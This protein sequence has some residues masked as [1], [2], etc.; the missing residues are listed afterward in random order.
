MTTHVEP[1]TLELVKVFL[2]FFATKRHGSGIGLTLVRRIA[3]AHS[4]NIEVSETPGGGTTINLRFG[5]HPAA[6]KV[7]HAALILHCHG[8]HR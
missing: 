3:A 7:R 1:E 4:S 5:G 2:P 8:A 6:S